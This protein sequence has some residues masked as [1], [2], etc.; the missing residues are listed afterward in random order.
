MY[1]FVD[2][3]PE[4]VRQ[5]PRIKEHL[6]RLAQAGRHAGVH[7]ILGA[8]HPLASELGSATLRNIPVRLVGRVAD[9][10]AAYNATGRS[11]SGAEHL[12]GGGDFVALNGA[13]KRHF[14]AA[15]PSA[16]LLEQWAQRY[17]PRPPRVPVAAQGRLREA[18]VVESAGKGASGGGRELDEIPGAVVE[19]IARYVKREQRFPSAY[20]VRRYTRET[21]P[22]GGFYPPKAWRAIEAAAQRLGVPAPAGNKPATEG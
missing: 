5:R 21:V 15:M 16:E 17:P 1:V 20:W 8:Q 14:Q 6:G 13:S 9:R 10:A 11:D 2:E 7:L 12:R 18:G 4:L 3:V 19:A 22:T